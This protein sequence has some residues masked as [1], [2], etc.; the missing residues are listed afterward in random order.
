[1]LR[2]PDTL[3]KAEKLQKVNCKLYINN[4]L[5]L[6]QRDARIFVRGHYLFQEGNSLCL[7]KTVSFEEQIM[8]KDKYLSIFLGQMEAIMFIVLQIFFAIHAV[9]QN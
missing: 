8:S 4:S 2:L 9:V 5:H 3:S 6:V 1:M 7:R